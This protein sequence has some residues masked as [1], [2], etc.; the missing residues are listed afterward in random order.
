LKTYRSEAEMKA[1]IGTIEDNDFVQQVREETAGF[2]QRL[3]R[4]KR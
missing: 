3:N 1:A 2:T 4:H